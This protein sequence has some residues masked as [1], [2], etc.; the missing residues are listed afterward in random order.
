[1]KVFIFLPSLAGGG[2]EHYKDAAAKI[3]EGS[4]V[5]LGEEPVLANARGF[6]G[7]GQE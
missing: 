4:K 7:F 3:M 1:M 5:V 6:F 2:A